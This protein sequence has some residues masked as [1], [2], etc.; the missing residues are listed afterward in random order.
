MIHLVIG[1]A[2]SGKSRFAESLLVNLSATQPELKTTYVATATGDDEEMVLRIKHHQTSRP[3]QWVLIEETLYLSKVV[4]EKL[5]QK[6]RVLIDCMTLWLSNWLCSENDLS[7][8]RLE[9]QHFISALSDT[10]ADIVIVSNEVGSGIVPMGSLSREF[11]DQAGWLNQQ[12]AA[13]ADKVT[14]VVAGLPVGLKGSD[15]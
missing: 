4:E 11:V 10:C 8:W 13:L 1:G 6:Q 14:L 12:L 5:Q 9:K 15:Y 2:R 7:Q 3:A